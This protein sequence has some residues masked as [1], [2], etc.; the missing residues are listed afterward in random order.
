MTSTEDTGA[1]FEGLEDGE[2]WLHLRC[3]DKSGNL[4]DSSA[5]FRVGIDTKALPPAIESASHPVQGTWSN[6]TTAEFSWAPPEDFSGIKGYYCVLDQKPGTYPN[7][8][9]GAFTELG[10]FQAELGKDGDWYFHVTSL[11]QAGNL[12]RDASH[13]HM[14]LDRRADPPRISSPS[15]PDP[16]RWHRSGRAEFRWT[17]PQDL[18]GIKGYY[19]VFDQSPDTVPT[20]E[21]GL[22][23]AGTS[24][25]I[26]APQDGQ[27]FFHLVTVDEAGNVGVEASDMEV[28]IDTRALPPRIESSSHPRGHW[29]SKT[30]AKFE[31][32]PPD[33]LSG[34]SA[35]YYALDK[36]ANTVPSPSG[37]ATTTQ[38]QI[39]F[40]GLT[41]G[42]WMLHVISEDRAGNVGSEAAHYPVWIDT[43]VSPPQFS[44]NLLAG[45]ER[46]IRQRS[47]DLAWEAPEDLS[48]IAEYLVLI[49]AEPDTVPTEGLGH[50]VKQ[51]RYTAVFEADGT[52]YFHVTCRDFAGNVSHQAA[53][54]RVNV[55][56][57][58]QA[59]Q[60]SCPS[61]PDPKA[62]HQSLRVRFEWE[63]PV[64]ASGING[65][66][67]SFDRDPKAVPSANH[68]YPTTQRFVEVSR[69][70]PQ[71]GAW[72]FHLVSKDRAGNVGSEASHWSVQFDTEALPPLALGSTSHPDPNAWSADPNPQFQWTAAPDLSGIQ[73]YYFLLDDKPSTIPGEGKGTW[74]TETRASIRGLKDGQWYFHVAS[75]DKAGNRSVR[76]AHFGVRVDTQ[77]LPPRQLVSPTHPLNQWIGEP[78]AVF[79]WAPAEDMS[80]IAGYHYLLDQ[81]PLTV[82][83][84]GNGQFSGA[85][86]ATVSGIKDGAWYF[87]VS[88]QDR[89]GN[90]SRQAA[91]LKIQVDTGA[92][93]PRV[94][95]S[96]HPDQDR[97]YP[98]DEPQFSWTPPA[99]PSGIAGYYYCVDQFSDTVPGPQ[100]QWT[101]DGKASPGKYPDGGWI[102]HL[103]T[104]DGAGNISSTATHV[105]FRVDSSLASLGGRFSKVNGI[106]PA[107]SLDLELQKEGSI[108]AVAV[109]DKSGNFEF[110]GIQPGV[111]SLKASEQGL[112]PL[113]IEGVRV[114]KGGMRLSLSTE[115]CSLQNFSLSPGEILFYVLAREAGSMSLKIYKESGTVVATIEAEIKAPVYQKLSWTPGP[116]ESGNYL[117]QAVLSGGSGKVWKYPIRKIQVA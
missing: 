21:T 111:Y 59:P 94:F 78:S 84:P 115:L 79:M 29:S 109:T 95:C 60:L 64:D 66:F 114:G 98:W 27:W 92:V 91:H 56:T 39:E 117:Y 107:D 63:E 52:W 53:H 90:N 80:G 86:M 106:S 11:D 74:T 8:A 71:D 68:G 105:R 70:L 31:L 104:K 17:E 24:M 65:Y 13:F 82:P 69:P 42:K 16:M 57:V 100:C 35:Y 54:L 26:D 76:A 81:K 40:K 5:H 102:F 33:D 22:F 113:F 77:V 45:Q 67:W 72:Y 38:R 58:A 2:W 4:G 55:D 3:E 116:G 88:C 36:E 112:P 9:V 101:T 62:W 30:H 87:H 12:S 83:G 25:G 48:G 37:A 46:W 41:D 89:A 108:A 18:S 103:S 34:V 73:G 19:A 15:H 61:H 14:R 99:E 20:A 49:D 23:V 75:Q 43:Q 32:I 47:V 85:M 97:G 93:P 50:C 28:R 10:A 6:R 51:P 44:K 7:S 110:P 1:Q 96:T